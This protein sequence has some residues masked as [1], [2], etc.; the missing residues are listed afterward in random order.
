MRNSI[1]KLRPRPP[2][3]QKHPQPHGT[4][5]ASTSWRPGAPSSD[6][7]HAETNSGIPIERCDTTVQPQW[8][9]CSEWLCLTFGGDGKS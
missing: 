3:A 2:S 8:G 4:L 1:R 5:V 9:L 7:R 6:V